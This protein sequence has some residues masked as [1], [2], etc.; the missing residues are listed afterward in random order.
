LLSGAIASG[1]TLTGNIAVAGQVDTYTIAGVAGGSIEAVVAETVA[2]SALTP[3]IQLIA[4]NGSVL[5]QLASA[6]GTAIESL[7]LAASGT[8]KVVV[9]DNSATKTGGYAVTAVSIG[10]GIA[11]SAGGDS[12]ATTSAVT[13]TAA[14]GAGDIDVFTINGLA[15][16]AIEAAVG[17]SIAG[18]SLTPLIEMFSPAGVRLTF[19]STSTGTAISSLSL[20]ASGTYTVVVRDNFGSATGGYS[21]TVVS[22]GTGIAQ[23]AGGDAGAT[24]SAV[25]R[26]ANIGIGD[27]DVFTINGLLG[28]AIE[29]A[30]GES[31]AGSTLTPLIELY[32]PA[33]VRLTFASSATGTVATSLSLPA[34]GT[35]TLVVRDYYGSAT[36]GY[37]MT[38]VSLGAGIAQDAGGDAGPTTSAVT[39]TAAI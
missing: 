39:K 13:K 27:I 24:N 9:T 7:N 31:I 26:T 12:G 21:I 3:K 11:Q 36:G 2:G 28:G 30:V 14:I 32:S 1:Q 19:A 18:S 23:D 38:A 4:P 25:T 37:S 33:G 8:Y 17:E 16:G 10:T 20:P 29:A 6:T 5:T 22:L 34:D 35:Y 15:G